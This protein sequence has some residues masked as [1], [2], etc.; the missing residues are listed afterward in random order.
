MDKMPVHHIGY[1]VRDIKESLK[2][3]LDLGYAIETDIVHDNV[4]QVDIMFLINNNIRI[5]LISP[6]SEES[7]VS[8]ILDKNGPLPYHICYQT[9]NIKTAILSLRKKGFMVIEKPQKSPAINNQ[10]VCFL[11][12]KNVGLIELVEIA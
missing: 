3:F 4:R 8:N 9:E 6:L 5:E 2:V 1:A 10:L 11:Y 7:P 12:H